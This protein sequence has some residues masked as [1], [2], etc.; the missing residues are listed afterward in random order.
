M[1]MVFGYSS[2]IIALHQGQVL[3]D[4]TPAGLRADKGVMATVTG[5]MPS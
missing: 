1:D 3:A 4:T 2:R 5:A